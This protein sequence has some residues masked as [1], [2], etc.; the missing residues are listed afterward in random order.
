VVA[1]HIAEPEQS[2]HAPPSA[3]HECFDVPVAQV[4]F[5]VQQ[6]AQV[7][8]SQR[9]VPPTQCWVAA[10]GLPI[11]HPQVPLARQVSA[12]CGS[13]TVQAPPL[14]PQLAGSRG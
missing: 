12:F 14:T 5:E 9:H 11:P 3:P 8:L 4:P 10:Q 13:H 2:A 7:V 1:L 6:P